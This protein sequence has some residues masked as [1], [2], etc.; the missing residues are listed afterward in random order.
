MIL[1]LLTLP[2][3]IV[4]VVGYALLADE[5]CIWVAEGVEFYRC[6][7]NFEFKAA[8]LVTAFCYM[9]T[10]M[11]IVFFFFFFFFF[12]PRFLN[13]KDLIT[14]LFQLLQE[15]LEKVLMNLKN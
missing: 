5:S 14:R 15:T 10:A 4:C 6:N 1:F 7:L 9:I 11:V 3:L 8:L 13:L 12:F 2:G